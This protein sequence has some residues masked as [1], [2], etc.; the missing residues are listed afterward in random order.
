MRYSVGN[1]LFTAQDTV[2]EL[3]FVSEVTTPE[4]GTVWVV[5]DLEDKNTRREAAEPNTNLFVPAALKPYCKD[6]GKPYPLEELLIAFLPHFSSWVY[7]VLGK[8]DPSAFE[9][10]LSERIKEA[11][12]KGALI[13]K[14]TRQGITVTPLEFVTWYVEYL[15]PP[16]AVMLPHWIRSGLVPAETHLWDY[17]ETLWKAE[18]IAYFFVLKAGGIANGRK[19]ASK[20]TRK[21]F[22]EALGV[23]NWSQ[24]EVEVL[25]HSLRARK[26]GT[27]NDWMKITFTQLGIGGSPAQMGL[28]IHVAKHNG[29]YPNTNRER[30]WDVVHDL[31][32]SFKGYFE[33]PEN[34]FSNHRRMGTQCGFAGIVWA[35]MR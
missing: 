17:M 30:R 3:E 11:I 13:A 31:N 29:I 12:D 27:A 34:L 14:A 18:M 33:L 32:E 35:G 10:E 24:I 19:V 26:A 4:W 8:T 21:G 22:A 7:F 6:Y 5:E 25:A 9:A 23:E 16:R 15:E 2:P 28:L 1:F 20:P